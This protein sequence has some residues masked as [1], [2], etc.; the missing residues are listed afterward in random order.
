ML[1]RVKIY[2]ENGLI[3]STTPSEDGV[4][5]LVATGVAV[6]NKFV[7]G[8]AYL[9]TSLSGLS[10][11]GITSG[12][13][14]ENKTIYKAVN[15]FYTEAPDGTKL[16]LKGVADTVTLA[17][18]MDVTLTP[19]KGLIDSANGAI[20]V[21]FAAKKDA[22]GY[23]ATIA[24]GLDTDVT[25]AITKSQ[26]LGEYATDTKYAP[27]FTIIPGRHYSGVAAD[28]ADLG[29]GASNRVCVMIGDT[30]ASSVDAAVGLLAGRIAAIPVQRSIAR[31]KSGAIGATPLYI[32]AVTAES[33]APDVINDGGYITFRTFVGKAGYYFTDDKLA[34]AVTDDYALIPRR[35]TIDKAYRIGYQTLINEL[36]DEIAV[37]DNGEI[38]ASSVKS[39]QNAV[40]TAIENNMAGEL[41]ADPS[42][43]T[44]TGVI[45]FIDHTQNVV[46]TSRLSV[47]LRVK[48]FGYPK[49]IDLYL[50]FKTATT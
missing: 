42:N 37:T 25:A 38:P 12:N 4:A 36:G 49:Y 10:V 11:L 44:D 34:T 28:L 43:P 26:A 32:G 2:F 46:S 45:C 47:K 33:G 19:A 1:P 30:V 6:T 5:G 7:L 24:N 9:I 20:K 41:G 40:E 50:G 48:P 17:N 22:T 35:R 27:L 29:T 23:T 8:T 21:L 18:M 31:V 3:G 14:D 16:W 15:D 13:A 39:I